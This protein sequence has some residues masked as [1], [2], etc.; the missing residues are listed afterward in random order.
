MRRIVEWTLK[1]GKQ[2]RVVVELITEKVV[3]LDGDKCLVD[4]CEILVTAEVEGHGVVGTGRPWERDGL[5]DGCVACIGKLA[6][7]AEQLQAIQAAIAEIEAS[8][9]W[10]AK[11]EAEAKAR[12]DLKE[13][14]KHR[15]EMRKIMGY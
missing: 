14:R 13:Y 3:D 2:A 10:Q 5:P 8:P 11:L 6:F 1:S 4:C 9:E 7:G 12:K 15:E